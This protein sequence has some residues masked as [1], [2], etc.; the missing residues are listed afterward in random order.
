[1]E[2]IE[3]SEPYST[4]PIRFLDL[5]EEA[6]WR[7][8]VYGISV[9]DPRPDTALVDAAK[10]LAFEQLP[11]PATTDNRYGV[12][13]LIVHEAREGNYIL[14]DWWFGE[15]MLKNFVYFSTHDDPTAF[16]DI[17]PTGTMACVWELRVL[18]HERQA[19]LDTMLANENGPDVE[20]YLSEEFN[21]DV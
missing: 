3:F 14:L 4:R 17:S 8:K 18:S 5:A 13:I 2:A 20:A 1:M 19:W 10:Q 11:S 21:A 6:G 7:I 12:A 16:E 9:H 15:N